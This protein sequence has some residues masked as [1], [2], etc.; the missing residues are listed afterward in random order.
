VNGSIEV[1]D[2][3]ALPSQPL[4]SV[5]M[6][7]Y[8]HER[9]IASAI[10]GVITQNTE[11]PIELIIGEDCSP[12]RTR[13]I[14]LDYQRRHPG[15]IRLIYSEA[16]VGAKANA[17][18]CQ[19][20]ARGEYVA[21]CE[22]DDYWS[23]PSKLQRQIDVFRQHPGASLVFHAARVIDEETGRD[24]RATRWPFRS[25]KFS[26][27]ELTIGDGGLVPTASIV[28]R[29]SV[30][31]R[32]RPWALE[33]PVGDYPMVL[34]AAIAGDVIYLDRVMSVYRANVPH[35][36]TKRHTPTL[37]N[38]LDYATRIEAML[39]ALEAEL[40]DGKLHAAREVISKYYSDVIVRCEGQRDERAEI[41]RIVSS[42][43]RGSDHWLAWLACRWNIRLPGVKTAI[44]RART[45]LRLLRCL[46]RPGI[47]VKEPNPNASP[48]ASIDGA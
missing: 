48:G 27:A 13:E 16:N 29:T 40:P 9:F 8:R 28:I 12:D 30:L 14:A 11:F 15:L 35:S 5:Y 44:R 25:R 6:L 38:R 47:G 26:L 22:G 42:K 19:A 21:I 2:P 37:A 45:V 46:L 20:A 7:A 43:L 17:A 36:W 39:Q 24:V 18:R 3:R 31:R 33:A 4:V 41:Y 32:R 23:D 10:E 1:S 34:S